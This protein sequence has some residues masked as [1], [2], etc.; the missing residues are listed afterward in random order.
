MNFLYINILSILVFILPSLYHNQNFISSSSILLSDNHNNEIQQQPSL[1]NISSKLKD[2]CQYVNLQNHN[3]LIKCL[4]SSITLNTNEFVLNNVPYLSNKKGPRYLIAFITRATENIHNYA[5][6]SIF[7][8]AIYTNLRGYAFIPILTNTS[9]YSTFNE[10]YLYYRKLSPILEA[11]SGIK[12]ST[13]INDK[14]SYDILD[15]GDN[16]AAFHSDYIVWLDADLIV[17][18][19]NMKIENLIGKYPE[20]H[21][22][23]SSDVS[24]IANTGLNKLLLL[25]LL[26]KI[27]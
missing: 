11:I 24:N 19:L 27:K 25:F 14:N 22:M 13:R 21:I 3:F 16:N 23:M 17:I 26:L 10:D 4:N 12:K 18:D 15:N 9:I 5:A 7:S 1:D 8:Q 20:A 2:C 6:Y